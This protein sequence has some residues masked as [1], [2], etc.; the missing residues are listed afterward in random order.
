MVL[1]PGRELA[2]DIRFTSAL[3][4]PEPENVLNTLIGKPVH[5]QL[6]RAGPVFF[7]AIPERIRRHTQFVLGAI[8]DARQRLWFTDMT[9]DLRIHPDGYDLMLRGLFG[10]PASVPVAPASSVAS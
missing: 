10:I 8:I 7:H 3:Q 6:L 1:P 5:A 4:P 2:V 9:T